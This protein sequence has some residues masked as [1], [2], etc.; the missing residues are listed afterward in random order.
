V[1]SKEKKSKLAGN[2]DAAAAKLDDSEFLHYLLEKAAILV[3]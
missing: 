3:K 1:Q 2:F